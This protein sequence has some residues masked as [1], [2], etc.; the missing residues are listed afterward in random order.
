MI[1]EMRAQPLEHA[2]LPVR[3]EA[4]DGPDQVVDQDGVERLAG[5]KAVVYPVA[6]EQAVLRAHGATQRG[7]GLVR[8]AA[9]GRDRRP[10]LGR[11][12][13]YP[14]KRFHTGTGIQDSA[15]GSFAVH[16][17]DVAEQG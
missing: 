13:L 17:F 10:A 4:F 16:A 7:A 9:G 8:Q 12:S 14:L 15:P 5:K 2:V 1:G 6:D 11:Q 3:G